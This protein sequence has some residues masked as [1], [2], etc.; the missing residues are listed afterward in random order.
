MLGRLSIPS[1]ESERGAELRVAV[2]CLPKGGAAGAGTINGD[3]IVR[4][5]C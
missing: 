2:M 3:T 1:L 4:H 5:S